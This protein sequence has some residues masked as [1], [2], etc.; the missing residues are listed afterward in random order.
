MVLPRTRRFRQNFR[1]AT[2]FSPLAFGT[3]CVLCAA[4]MASLVASAQTKLSSAKR[5]L[6]R[7][8][9]GELSADGS[10]WT[11]FLEEA[12][13]DAVRAHLQELADGRAKL[14]KVADELAAVV[15]LLERANSS[16][17]EVRARCCVFS[18]FA[19][20]RVSVLR[21]CLLLTSALATH[22][23]VRVVGA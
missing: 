6:S 8:A 5:D 20:A 2:N 23:V 3:R 15:T 9:L 11:E 13:V 12:D 17:Q 14:T 4:L 16:A 18:M 21:Q 7:F 19:R 22:L 1:F 10:M